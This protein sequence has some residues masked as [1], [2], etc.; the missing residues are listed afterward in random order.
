MH[1]KRISHTYT[2]HLFSNIFHKF[3]NHENGLTTFIIIRIRVKGHYLSNGRIQ[4]TDW[5]RIPGSFDR[6]RVLSYMLNRNI[7]LKRRSLSGDI[8]RCENSRRAILRQKRDL[9]SSSR[10]RI[11]YLVS[12]QLVNNTLT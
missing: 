12:E 10:M 1:L 3:Q 4:D 8:K 7:P 2:S 9:P 5:E 6:V 11:R